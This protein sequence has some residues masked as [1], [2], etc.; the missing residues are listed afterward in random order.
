MSPDLPV[1]RTLARRLLLDVNAA[2]KRFARDHRYDTGAELRRDAREVAR[3]AD[4][5]WFDRDE[6]ASRIK[7]L[8]ETLDDFKLTLQ[9]AKDLQAF[10]GWRQFE[11]IWRIVEDLG[12]QCGGWHRHHQ[13]LKGQNPA[14]PRA[15]PER[16]KRLSVRAASIEANT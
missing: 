15:A 1:I 14:A 2:V 4:R 5:A 8:V 13:H 11:A 9:L 10:Q 7:T 16:A 3:A 12:A 6:R